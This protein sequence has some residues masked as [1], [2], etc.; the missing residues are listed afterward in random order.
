VLSPQERVDLVLASPTAAAMFGCAD[1]AG[2]TAEDLADPATAM[3]VASTAMQK[4]RPWSGEA[5]YERAAARDNVEGLRDLVTAVVGDTRNTWWWADLQRDRQ[6]WV[7]DITLDPASFV[8]PVPTQY[9]RWMIYAQHPNYTDCID[10]STELDVAPAQV[11]SG[12]HNEL[13]GAVPTDWNPNY[14]LR[15]ARITVTNTARVYEIHQPQAWHELTMRYADLDEYAGPDTN[16]LSSAG[17]DHGPAPIW[18]RVAADWDG[19]HLSF[20]GL[21]TTLY[22]PL[23]HDDITTT[24]W[25]WLSERTLWL[26][27]TFQTVTELE[28]LTETPYAAPSR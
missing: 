26:R 1:A 20:F 23:T 18:H 15:Q 9:T 13:A 6:L 12:L 7:S 21:L 4:L 28:P 3:A 10:T 14:P 11:R 16:L 17:I 8:L 27:N 22:R 24:L 5:A 19:V 2:L 25:A